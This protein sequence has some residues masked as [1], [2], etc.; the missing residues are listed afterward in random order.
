MPDQIASTPDVYDLIPKVELHCH[1]EGAIRPSTM[2]A[3]ARDAGRE[4]PFGDLSNFQGFQSIYDFRR[5]FEIVLSTLT[6]PDHWRR[7]AYESLLDGAQHGL[8][9]REL[10]FTPSRHMAQ[11]QDLGAIIEAL[12]EGLTAAEDETG[13]RCQLIASCDRTLDPALGITL[14]DELVN[15]RRSGRADRVIGIG[16]D[17]PHSG[18]DLQAWREAFE[19][20]GKAG[21]Y[22]TAHAQDGSSANVAVTLDRLGVDRIDHA[23]NI[24]DD[25]ALTDRVAQARIP[26]T[27]CPNSNVKIFA[28]YPS[29]EEHP[30]RRMREA[31]LLA[32]LNTDDPAMMAVSLDEEYRS[33]A[34]AM[35]FDFDDM[36]AISLDGIEA[37][38]LDESEKRSMRAL[39]QQDLDALRH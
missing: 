4:L 39:F 23:M 36:A 8:R 33:V 27:V 13:A 37:S 1:V 18:F 30:Y 16:I 34:Q 7:I 35:R 17:G 14:V 3:F 21:L 12:S 11:G 25:P 22:R 6:T 28:V 32:T 29:L 2:A 10:H 19:I 5:A 15:L 24:L 38:W 20:A 26:I 31:G 9:Y